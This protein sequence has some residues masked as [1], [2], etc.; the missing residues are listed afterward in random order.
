ML[1][2][3]S[4]AFFS[5]CRGL[6]PRTCPARWQHP[7]TSDG[8]CP[9]QAERLSS[10]A[11]ATA[12]WDETQEGNFRRRRSA[13]SPPR[14]RSK[15][16]DRARLP[17]TGTPRS[18][19]A[20]S[21]SRAPT[22]RDPRVCPTPQRS[23]AQGSQAQTR[24][25]CHPRRGHSAWVPVAGHRCPRLTSPD[26]TQSPA[27]QSTQ[28]RGEQGAQR[29]SRRSARP[30]RAERTRLPT[31]VQ[32]IPILKCDDQKPQNGSL[33]NNTEWRVSLHMVTFPLKQN[34]LRGPIKSVPV[35]FVSAVIGHS[36]S[37]SLT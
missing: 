26:N 13:P 4:T 14:F 8:P 34:K 29:P 7:P 24:I 30:P 33:L 37:N 6:A 20:G 25:S 19:A 31:G 2:E 21:S 9:R 3:G 1:K 10:S 17:R 27:A 35:G 32:N 15:L 5:P 11:S 36:G 23:A 28:A 12:S 22:C 16:P 18:R